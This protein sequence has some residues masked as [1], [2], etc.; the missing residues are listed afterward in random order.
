MPKRRQ[1][2]K[3]SQKLRVVDANRGNPAFMAPGGNPMG[4]RQIARI[5]RPP[6]GYNGAGL[7][8][9]A[10]AYARCLVD[11]WKSPPAA[12][13][14]INSVQNCFVQKSWVRGTFS[15]NSVGYGFVAIDPFA[16]VSDY[17]SLVPAPG[18]PTNGIGITGNAL[19]CWAS[20]TH[21]A[22]PVAGG[23]NVIAYPSNYAVGAVAVNGFNHNGIVTT[24]LVASGDFTGYVPVACG[25]Y[26][27]NITAAL[28]Q[29]GMSVAVREP[30][31]GTLYAYTLADLLG[32]PGAVQGSGV[33]AQK[34]GDWTSVHYVPIS[35]TS[36]QLDGGVVKFASNFDYGQPYIRQAGDPATPS[37]AFAV[38]NVFTAQTFEFQAY[39]VGQFVGENC[40]AVQRA[41]MDKIGAVAIANALGMRESSVI[42]G[43]ADQAAEAFIDLA[44]SAGQQIGRL[45]ATALSK[46]AL[47][48]L[49]VSGAV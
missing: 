34:A 33:A 30:E 45:T 26:V 12:S 10:R 42:D 18:P 7:S 48:L 13:C 49:R 16:P 20:T 24:A 27:K 14:A 21:D 38:Q 41:F 9:I 23:N 31:N 28:Y 36:P 2:K 40:L 11:P 4:S 1:K 8:E 46:G 17:Q 47:A 35:A 39:W 43:F 15:T 19:P 3:K 32:I 5:S 6:R 22:P 37:L 25:L 44:A 29:G